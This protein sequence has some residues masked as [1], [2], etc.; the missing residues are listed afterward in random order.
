MT[1]MALSAQEIQFCNPPAE[2]R[3]ALVPVIEFQMQATAAAL[4]DEIP[5]IK[6]RGDSAQGDPRDRLAIIRL[7]MRLSP[8]VPI[9]LLL[10]VT[11]LA[12]R[13]LK[14]WLEWWGIP[15]TVTGFCTMFLAA[16]G[17]PV[18]RV[19]LQQALAGNLPAYLPVSILDFTTDMAG[20]AAR[21]IMEPVVGQ[22]LILG[23]VGLI[24]LLVSFLRTRSDGMRARARSEAQTVV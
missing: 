24:M 23:V 11:L 8:L 4:P 5:L 22:G 20:T 2:L 17:G 6:P 15:L 21:E 14:N 9:G 10:L 19:M 18:V 3:S 16:L 1:V 7:F 12:V 13:S